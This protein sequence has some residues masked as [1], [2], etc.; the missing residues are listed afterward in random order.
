MEK[1]S[2]IIES[3]IYTSKTNDFKVAKIYSSENKKAITISGYLPEINIGSTV[4]LT[5]N[6]K[7]NKEFGMEFNV[8]ECEIGL[9]STE[10]EMEIYLGSGTLKGVGPSLAKS[11][12]K[13]FGDRIFEVIE[14]E[15]RKLLSVPKI[16]PKKLELIIKSWNEQKG[17]KDLLIFLQKAGLGTAIAQKIFK[18]Y[19]EESISKIKNNPYDLIYDIKGINFKIADS[20]AKSLNFDNDFYKRCEA[21]I[22]YILES[23]SATEGHC[24]IPSEELAEKCSKILEVD[25]EKIKDVCENLIKE[26]IIIREEDK[27]YLPVFYNSEIFLAK[28]IKSIMDFPVFLKYSEDEN[29]AEIDKTERDIGINYDDSQKEAINAVLSSNFSVITGGAGVGKTTITEAI[30]NILKNRG[31]SIILTAPTGRAA[32][33]LS[34]ISKSEAKTIHRLLEAQEGGRFGKNSL[35]KLAGSALIVDEASMIDIKLMCNL[36]KAVP[37]SMTVILIGD[38]NQLPSVGPGNILHD[39]IDS[40]TVP[41]IKLNKIYRQSKISDIII[42]SHKINQGEIPDLKIKSDSDFF[43]IEN[44]NSQKCADTI[45]ELYTKR[46]PNYYKVNPVTDIQVLS[47]MKKGILGTD[48]LNRILQESV[49]KNSLSLTYNAVEYKLKDKVMQ[50]KNNYDK[51]IFNGDMGIISSINKTANFLEVDFD[52]KIV[53]YNISELNELALAYACTIHKSQGGEYPIIIIP[54]DKSHHIMLERN[55]LYTAITRAKKVCILIGRKE[56]IINAVKTNKS[57]L[58]YTTFSKRLKQQFQTF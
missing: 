26:K 50:I 18:V 25:A 35:N 14:N 20:I 12:V 52:S 44:N 27:I 49:N 4:N 37:D 54:M 42:N 9:P 30:I 23:L 41:I 57:K 47:P 5:G 34:E 6:W 3:V 28:K 7:L 11:M 33:R 56:C 15:P 32:K 51:D 31:K 38:A 21:G 43:F 36:F 1:I 17:T 48:N 29:E 19:G 22:I 53:K 2:G 24:Y 39:I 45:I 55:L 46:L 10:R 40:Q 16:G 58:R 13:F 8:T